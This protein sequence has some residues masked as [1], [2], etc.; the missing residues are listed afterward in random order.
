MI[1]EAHAGG[2]SLGLRAAVEWIAGRL[3]ENNHESRTSVSLITA[4]RI[5]CSLQKENARAVLWR[6]V[7]RVEDNVASPV[8]AHVDAMSWQ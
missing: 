6:E 7:C 4:Q 1:L 5:A 8:A 3:A 2:W